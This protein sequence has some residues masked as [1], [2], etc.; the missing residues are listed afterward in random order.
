MTEKEEFQETKREFLR[1]FLKRIILWE[2]SYA[3]EIFLDCLV[4]MDDVMEDT[5]FKDE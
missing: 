3:T 2:T 1:D 4:T 5:K